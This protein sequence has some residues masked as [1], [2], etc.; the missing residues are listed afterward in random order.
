M[1]ISYTLLKTQLTLTEN[2]NH[3]LLKQ[4]GEH[5]NFA[6]F[7]INFIHLVFTVV[8]LTQIPSPTPY[9]FPCQPL[10]PQHKATIRVTTL[11][12]SEL[13]L[14]IDGEFYFPAEFPGEV[15]SDFILLVSMKTNLVL[16]RIP[17]TCYI[18]VFNLIGYEFQLHYFIHKLVN[19]SKKLVN[20]T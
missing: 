13:A 18:L 11:S 7:D 17:F 1:M 15:H 12:V 20:T 16:F 2:T 10:T 3:R 9:P 14:H 19:T 6:T 8:E 4:H 5:S